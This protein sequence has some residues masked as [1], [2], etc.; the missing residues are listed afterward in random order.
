MRLYY[1]TSAKHG[2]AAIESQRYK[3]S[4]FDNLNDPFELFAADFADPEIRSAFRR[5]KEKCASTIALL[6]CSKSWGST[7][8]WS[9]YADRHAGVA[10]EL[11]VDDASIIHV[12]YQEKRTPITRQAMDENM[13]R[14]NGSGIGADMLRVK[15]LDWAYEDEAR[16]IHDISRV[17]RP[18]NG[19]YFSPFNARIS[20]R[21]VIIGPLCAVRLKQ[22]EDILPSGKHLIVARARIAFRSFRVVADRS[23]APRQLGPA[24]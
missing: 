4:T 5:F 10:L 11:E 3:L 13:T 9:H 19:L 24:T 7:L 15:A 23:F 20:L 21:G 18:T 12:T 22:I 2:L 6:C 14:Q 16:I 8:L 17:K 1:F